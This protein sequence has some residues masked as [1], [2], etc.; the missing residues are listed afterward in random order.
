M[1]MYRVEPCN[2]TGIFVRVLIVDDI[3]GRFLCKE[4]NHVS[5]MWNSIARVNYNPS[6][7]GTTA[8][9][10]WLSEFAA[11]TQHIGPALCNMDTQ[12]LH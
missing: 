2:T 11:L 1:F 6:G 9:R 12:Y 10:R 5:T 7:N 4:V 8:S 3:Y